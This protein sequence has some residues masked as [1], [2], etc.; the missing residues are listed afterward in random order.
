MSNAALD[1]WTL[2]QQGNVV[3]KA[4][5]EHT[6]RAGITRCGSCGDWHGGAGECQACQRVNVGVQLVA[7]VGLAMVAAR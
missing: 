5:L 1:H 4:W 7:L 2:D 6:R 3:S